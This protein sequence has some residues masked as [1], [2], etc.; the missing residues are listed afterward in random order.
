MPL[1]FKGQRR[2]RRRGGGRRRGRCAERKRPF[3][4]LV[5]RGPRRAF[6]LAE[7]DASGR[8]VATVLLRHVEPGSMVYT[9]GFRGYRRVSG[10]G[11]EHLSVMHSGGVHAAGPVHVNNAESRNWHLRAFLF[12]K[13]SVSAALAGF[14]AA[15]ASQAPC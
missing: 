5:E 14:Y 6:F 15:A 3:F 9:D 11:Y 7:G 12:F 1:G 10:L 2:A 4:T 13:H 8:T